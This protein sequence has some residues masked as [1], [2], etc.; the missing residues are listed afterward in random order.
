MTLDDLIV[1][2][3]LDVTGFT[4][5]QKAATD[6]LDKTGKEAVKSAKAIEA[7][8]V[9]ASQGVEK[10]A[11]QFLGLYALL[12]GG[13]EIKQFLSDI[14]AADAA[15]GRTAKNIDMSGKALSTWQ[16]V[17]VAAGGSAEGITASMSGL[18]NAM[19]V[20]A[21]TGE[22]KLAPVFR[23]MGI[24][25]ATTGGK[26]RDVGA[27]M[28]DLNRRYNEMHIDPARF[29]AMMKM[30]GMDDGTINLL[31][32]S[33]SE[34]R[35]LYT[36]QQKYA[37]TA[38]DIDAAQKRQTGWRE[39]ILTSSSLGRTIATALTPVMV[40]AMKGVQGWASANQEWIKSAI[41]EKV[42]EFV[43]WL[44]S[45]DWN[46]IGKGAQDFGREVLGIATALRD[47]AKEVGTDSALFKAFEVFGALLLGGKVLGAIN[48][49]TAAV[50]A[51]G[52]LPVPPVL[53]SLL[54]NPAVL[55]TAAVGAVL[56]SGD[57]NKALLSGGRP[58]V[59]PQD[60]DLGL[61]G[62]GL[63]ND[64]RP[65]DTSRP[66]GVLDWFKANAM[67]DFGKA[68]EQ[69]KAFLKAT[70]FGDRLHEDPRTKENIEDTAKATKETRDIL[71]RQADAAALGGA[72]V[73]GVTTSS[74]GLGGSGQ[75]SD[76][77]SSPGARIGDRAD[78]RTWYQRHAP[79]ALGGKDAPT[80]IMPE[81]ADYIAREAAKRGIDP[82]VALQVAAS[83]GARGYD[84]SKPDRGGDQGTSFGPFQLHYK[85]D[86]PGF[87]NAGMGDDFTRQTGKDARD[88]STWKDQVGF[89][90]DHAA[91][92]GWRNWHGWK[93]D[94]NAG[95]GL[96]PAEASK[97]IPSPGKLT[98]DRT[99]S[100]TA[101]P[102]PQQPFADPSGMVSSDLS[103][104]ATYNHGTLDSTK[105][106]IF[107]HTGGRGSPEGVVDTL[108]QRGLGV[109]YV[110]DRDGKITRTLPEGARGAHILRS[111]I[112]GLN[113]GNTQGV[114]VIA[115]DDKDV[116]PAQ[117]AAGR[118]FAEAM[119]KRYPGLQVFGHGE[120][121]PSHKQADEG[122]S[123]VEAYRAE[124]GK[125]TVDPNFKPAP[126]PVAQRTLQGYMGR[127][128]VAA[129]KLD[130]ARQKLADAMQAGSNGTPATPHH[131]SVHHLLQQVLGVIHR[132]DRLTRHD[133]KPLP[134][135]DKDSMK[136]HEHTFGKFIGWGKRHPDQL[137]NARAVLHGS[138]A[139]LDYHRA[140]M[141]GS[142]MH[143]SSVT[144]TA[145]HYDYST[146]TKIGSIAVHTQAKD[147]RQ[148]ADD[149]RP[150][151]FQ[152]RDARQA[153][154]GLA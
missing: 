113:N 116:T 1:R 83:E 60:N 99:Q 125:P 53:G 108:N 120:V 139:A 154:R 64:N 115:K 44:R 73:G 90:L 42:G 56:A 101:Q 31:E 119:A 98:N 123:I 21:L 10:L 130:P 43:T 12:T 76:G 78:H 17:A 3:T 148:V 126:I 46:A 2:L 134:V 152:G 80:G 117:V 127:D 62:T 13:R 18:S 45:L 15:V 59:Q 22:N 30:V 23:A 82:R 20:A 110:M 25:L 33:Q 57:P 86:I 71:K 32:R 121:N 84:P 102:N 147:A 114:E 105:G 103:Q 24:N 19:Q 137:D 65:N 104:R 9:S 138:R 79:K 112:N 14:T 92:H 72:A 145:H 107:H 118:A 96:E 77:T 131:A 48:T 93:G 52:R 11:R 144:H 5:G 106:L 153:N 61:P 109:Q 151:L 7:S 66:R 68:G 6:S 67:P 135:V 88:S 8:A 50:T 141:A 124:A 95:L 27:I 87:R 89:A 55:G 132:A 142:N 36:E 85:S 97:L 129:P 74:G 91:K 143:H 140:V 122:R 41:V 81:V 100:S 133:G 63:P 16:G 146:D 149:L 51:F 111:E 128:D 136:L 47:T 4:A 38:E 39:L 29:S 28:F 35:K 70:G 40:D 37:A 94:A 26:A 150:Y 49:V 69:F 34:F 75:H 58:D 54:L